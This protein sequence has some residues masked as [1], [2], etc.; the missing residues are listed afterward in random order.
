MSAIKSDGLI[1]R[2]CR[3]AA[4]MMIS[5]VDQAQRPNNF[6]NRQMHVMSLLCLMCG[7]VCYVTCM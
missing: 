2:I 4:V 3:I 1:V 6:Y 7:Y 5:L